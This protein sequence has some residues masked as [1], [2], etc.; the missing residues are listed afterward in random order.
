MCFGMPK[1][2]VVLKI[3]KN[4]KKDKIMHTVSEKSKIENNQGQF[5]QYVFA[6]GVTKEDEKSFNPK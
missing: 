3:K 1:Y 6:K 5:S 4:K 2:R